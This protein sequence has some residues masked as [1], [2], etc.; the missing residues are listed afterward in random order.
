M[1]WRRR[2]EE[3]KEVRG[4]ESEEGREKRREEEDKE[5]KKERNAEKQWIP[6][7]CLIVK[8]KVCAEPFSWT[9]PPPTDL[10][11]PERNVYYFVFM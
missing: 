1:S 3:K 6:S 11:F 8:I 7:C 2:K 4:G 9:P 5:T 10:T